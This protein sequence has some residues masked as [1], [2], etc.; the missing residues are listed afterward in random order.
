EQMGFVDVGG[1]EFVLDPKRHRDKW[2]L[3]GNGE[4]QRA[5]RPQLYLQAESEDPLE[6]SSDESEQFVETDSSGDDPSW[7][8]E[9]ALTFRG[10]SDD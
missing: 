1:N 5:D 10:G 9:R 7:Y 2:T 3:N 8:L 6:G 4:W